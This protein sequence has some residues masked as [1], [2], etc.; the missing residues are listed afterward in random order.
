MLVGPI[1]KEV[2][3]CSMPKI[4]RE[5]GNG[6]GVF[7]ANWEPGLKFIFVKSDCQRSMYFTDVSEQFIVAVQLCR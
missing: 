3:V 6:E 4:S 2:W 7:S 1:Q 5:V